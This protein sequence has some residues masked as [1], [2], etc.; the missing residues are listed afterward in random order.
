MHPPMAKPRMFTPLSEG[1]E[2]RIALPEIEG[3]V[4]VC[5]V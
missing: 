2:H 1:P 5:R 4:E 3:G